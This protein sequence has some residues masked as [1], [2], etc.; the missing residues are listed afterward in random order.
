MSNI[1]WTRI[2]NDSN[3]NSRFVCSWLACLPSSW[4]AHDAMLNSSYNRVVA[5]IAR[6]GGRK[7]H[8]RNYAGGIVFTEYRGCL[9]QLEAK[10][11]ELKALTDKR[12]NVLKINNWV[13]RNDEFE[14]LSSYAVIVIDGLDLQHI[15]DNLKLRDKR[16]MQLLRNNGINVYASKHYIED[17]GVNY[18]VHQIGSNY[19]LYAIQY[20]E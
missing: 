12:H 6:I 16:I 7:F 13:K 5:L 3:G 2:N 14:W 20:G 19:P 17:D 15:E 1:N 8:N 11:E 18:V 10:I 4:H 9:D